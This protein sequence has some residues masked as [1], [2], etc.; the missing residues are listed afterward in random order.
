MLGYLTAV[1]TTRNDYERGLIVGYGTIMWPTG[2]SVGGDA[3]PMPVYIVQREGCEGSS[4]LGN[5]VVVFRAD[6]V[7]ETT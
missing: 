4:S 7:E 2:P 1:R 6:Q 3:Q 5:A